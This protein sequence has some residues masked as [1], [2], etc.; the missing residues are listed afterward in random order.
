MRQGQVTI[1][2]FLLLAAIVLVTLIGLTMVDNDVAT[3]FKNLFTDVVGKMPLDDGADAGVVLP[4]EEP[5]TEPTP[6]PPPEPPF[7]EYP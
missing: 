4:P 3:T 1:E 2:Y 7:P 5:P 6:E